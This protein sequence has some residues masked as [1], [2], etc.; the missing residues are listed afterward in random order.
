M[1]E[2]FAVAGSVALDTDVVPT[3]Q[4]ISE[5]FE[6]FEAGKIGSAYWARC[7]AAMAIPQT[8]KASEAQTRENH[9]LRACRKS[10]KGGHEQDLPDS[11]FRAEQYW[12]RVEVRGLAPAASRM[13]CHGHASP[14]PWHTDTQDTTEAQALA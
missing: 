8:G 9:H 10:R 12:E 14:W 4:E 1:V 5:T 2:E 6:V 11:P 13:V 3:R 7:L